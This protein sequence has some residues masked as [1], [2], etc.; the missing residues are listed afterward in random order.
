MSDALR[1]FWP[2]IGTT[3]TMPDAAAREILRL[4]PDPQTIF[5]ALCLATVLS[6]L[7]TALLEL[8]VPTP[9]ELA[10]QMVQIT[11]F[12]YAVV[13]MGA[14][15]ALSVTLHWTG[16]S[17][18]GQGQLDDTVAAVTW[19]QFVLLVLQGGQVILSL[20]SPLLG[21]LAA[22]ASILVLLWS[23]INFMDVIHGF[24]SRFKAA[25]VVMV[26]FVGVAIGL[27][28]ILTM[29]GAGTAATQGF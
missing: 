19:L 15:L 9:P 11:P 12:A 13:L 18:G 17:L 7:M 14:L 29:I 25:G 5:Q 22:M 28:L 10:D 16:A 23:L 24:G 4:R 27:G 1:Q 3:I 21:G 2:L 8:A 26:A 20:V 6:V